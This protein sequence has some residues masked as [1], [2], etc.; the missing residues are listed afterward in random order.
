LVEDGGLVADSTRDLA[1]YQFGA[2]QPR[3]RSGIR[4]RLQSR[5]FL[6]WHL[7]RRTSALPNVR[8]LHRYEATEPAI[9]SDG[10][11]Q[12]LCIR[13]IASGKFEALTTELVVDAA[14]RGSST[15]RWLSK[16]GFD[17]PKLIEIGLPITYASRFFVS[18]RT[19]HDWSA[20]LIYPTVPQEHRGGAL[21]FQEGGRWIATVASY[22][23][24]PA[25]RDDEGF[26]EFAAGLPNPEIYNLIRDATPASPIHTY[27]YPAAQRR[28]YER[29]RR[30]L[31]RLVCLGDSV[32]SFNPVFGQG[33]TSAALQVEAL[34]RCLDR[35]KS[36]S[37][38]FERQFA[39]RA[40]RSCAQPWFMSTTMDLRYPYAKGDRPFWSPAMNAYLDFFFRSTAT[41][42]SALEDF[43]SV[44]HL[45]KSPTE[46]L[47]PSTVIRTILH[48]QRGQRGRDVARRP[49]LT[50]YSEKGVRLTPNQAS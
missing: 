24:E 38:H 25:P 3:G 23:G 49:P 47:R 41:S 11:V 8:F 46:W 18:P 5:P 2:W 13:S 32:A 27:H 15:P 20:M 12:G 26:L 35:D 37:R 31:S 29:L 33:M 14:G 30:P 28:A 43:M 42:Q 40:A 48:G 50:N 22:K 45:Q 36:L 39:K 16:A 1:F 17:P 44:L 7:Y 21:Y 6:E 10:R 34:E 4:T 9:D 19:S